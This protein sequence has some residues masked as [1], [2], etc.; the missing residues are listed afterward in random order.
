MSDR[1]DKKVEE[2][3]YYIVV[4]ESKGWLEVNS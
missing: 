1:E 4:G 2:R 3:W